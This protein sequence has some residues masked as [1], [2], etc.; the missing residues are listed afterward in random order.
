MLVIT[1]AISKDRPWILTTPL[2]CMVKE[3][4]VNMDD[5]LKNKTHD[6]FHYF[7]FYFLFCNNFRLTEKLQT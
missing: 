6:H 5:K 3:T 4:Q 1:T 2:A 7:S